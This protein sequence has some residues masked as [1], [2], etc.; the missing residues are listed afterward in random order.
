VV[1]YIDASLTNGGKPVVVSF[2]KDDDAAIAALIA[3]ETF[4][5]YSVS[6]S[7]AVVTFTHGTA[8]TGYADAKG[9]SVTF[10]P[11]KDL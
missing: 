1:V 6:S 3:V 4:A 7:G 5:G 11:L 8:N 9:P 10:I 2:A